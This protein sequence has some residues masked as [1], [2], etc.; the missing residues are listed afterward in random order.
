MLYKWLISTA[1]YASP[2][3][4]F[5]RIWS[6]RGRS[7]AM[8]LGHVCWC[9]TTL[10]KSC[11]VFG[12][13]MLADEST[14]MLV[15]RWGRVAWIHCILRCLVQVLLI[16]RGPLKVSIL[17]YGYEVDGY[18]RRHLVARRRCIMDHHGIQRCVKKCGKMLGF[19]R[20]TRASE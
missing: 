17:C 8:V 13:G 14:S 7:W 6:L 9:W 5:W 18:R 4:H 11:W 3:Q 10:I 2:R 19:T 16:K 15:I 20:V 12:W 1:F